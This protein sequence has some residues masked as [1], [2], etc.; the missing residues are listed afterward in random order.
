MV[1]RCLALLLATILM[2]N[3]LPADA[4]T[5]DPIRHTL[6]FPAPQTNRLEVTSVVPT[7]QRPEVELMMAVWTPGSYLVREY[8]RNVEGIAASDRDGRPL[9]IVKSAKNR[10]RITTGG[11]SAVSVTYQVYSREMTPRYNWVDA[12]FALVNGAPTFMTIAGDLAR[13]HEVTIVPAA[14]WARSIT[15]LPL[16]AG[17]AT[18][19]RADNFDLLVDSPILVG[20][21]DVQTFQIDGKT[22]YL[23]TEGAAGLFDSARA[24]RDLEKLIAEHRKMWGSLPF[25]RYVFFNMLTLPPGQGGGALEHLSSVLMFGDKFAMRTKPAYTAWLQLASHEFFHVWNVKRLRP[26][27]LGPFD[28]ERE[29]LTK[30]LWIAEGVT[31]YY[32]DLL[33][34][35]AGFTS[36][37]EYLQSLSSKIDETQNTPGRLLQSVEQSSLDAWIRQYRPD[38]NSIN[39]AISYYTK[40]HVLGFLLDARIRTLT[41]GSK[42]LDD[43]MRLAFARY[44]GIRGYTPGEFLAVAEEVAGT[45]LRPF[46]QGAIEGTAELD[47]ADALSTFGLRFRDAPSG[48]RWLGMATRNDAGR[49]VVAQL[50]RDGPS[51]LAGLNVDDEIIG[52]DDVRVRAD[53]F[54]ARL[55]QYNAGDRITLLI[56]RRDQIMRV[57]V[58][59][60]L[61]PSRRW[62]LESSGSSTEAQRRYL[63]SWLGLSQ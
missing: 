61:E 27:E 50:R 9:P 13:P 34:R 4:Q 63:S 7:G 56:V 10:W 16:V 40:G 1:A 31:D 14:G 46:W 42:S 25:D 24:V 35:R 30:S 5:A 21:P 6:R 54:D 41:G 23:A 12:S 48:G 44:S 28:Y 11:A 57:P 47:Y 8:A 2:T 58:T 17:S 22:H 29:V 62:R 32:G 60:A 53:R 18:T 3:A 52:I 26:V 15:S 39:V 55:A 51:F 59:L 36:E 38:E 20:N 49:L 45:S 33:V 43:V 19:Y 37:D